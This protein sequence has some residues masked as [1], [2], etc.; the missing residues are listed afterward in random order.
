MHGWEFEQIIVVG[1]D[2]K[3]FHYLGATQGMGH[4]CLHV[5]MRTS[6][7]KPTHTKKHQEWIKNEKVMAP[8][9]K[10]GSRTKKKNH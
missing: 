2:V 3:F 6:S 1:L 9:S 7:L 10:G 4:Y 8:Q 5:V